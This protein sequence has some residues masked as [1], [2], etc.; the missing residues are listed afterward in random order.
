MTFP[1]L[2]WCVSPLIPS[3]EDVC[4]TLVHICIHCFLLCV[5]GIVPTAALSLAATLRMTQPTPN[6]LCTFC[7]VFVCLSCVSG[8]TVLL[9]PINHL[10][11]VSSLVP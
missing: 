11:Y 7:F 9:P 8:I 4:L 1:M 3:P 5:C 10:D 2:Q 6:T